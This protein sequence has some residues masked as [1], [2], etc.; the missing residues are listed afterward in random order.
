MT[1]HRRSPLGLAAA[2]VMATVPCASAAD[3]GKYRE[4]AGVT[5]LRS[6]SSQ[7]V[8]LRPLAFD[9]GSS[10]QEV[11]AA[12]VR[13]K[14]EP[15][16]DRCDESTFENETPPHRDSVAGFWMARTEV[17]VAQYARCVAV[18]RCSPAGFEG[19]ALRFQRSAYP[20]TFVTFED[21][22]RYCAFRGG[23]L[24]SEAEF[25]R[26]ARGAPR[27]AY[28]W[29]QS[30]HGKLSNHGRLGVDTT[31]ASDGFAELA[32]V[33]SFPDGAT[34]EGILDLAGNAAEWSADAFTPDYGSPAGSDRAVRGGSF[35]SSAAFVRGAA[36][37]GKASETREPTL[38][39]R[40]VWPVRPLGD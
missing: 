27:R 30:Y 36:R 35:M 6:P 26:A 37:A 9:M 16:A 38:G 31:D 1:Q 3:A 28:P 7:A 40:C 8:Y 24:P 4:T 14:R 39:F 29:G 15:L 20:V 5:T 21:A 33:G 23:R 2:L 19:G 11:L 22:K 34:P 12:L 32:P 18:G 10:E 25:E 13:C 17:T